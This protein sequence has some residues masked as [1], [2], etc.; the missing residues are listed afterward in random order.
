M[1]TRHPLFPWTRCGKLKRHVGTFL[2]YKAGD[3]SFYNV[4]HCKSHIYTVTG[5]FSSGPFQ[6]IFSCRTHDGEKNLDPLTICPVGTQGPHW[7]PN[8]LHLSSGSWPCI[9]NPYTQESLWNTYWVL[10]AVG[11]IMNKRIVPAMDFRE[12]STWMLLYKSLYEL[13]PT[14]APESESPLL[15]ALRPPKQGF[16]PS[17]YPPLSWVLRKPKE[18]TSRVD[19]H[20]SFLYLD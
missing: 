19:C 16:V 8:T 5:F 1:S 15:F 13:A 11:N 4:T 17:F 20:Q 9:S 18:K 7:M 10:A 6:P 12:G 3:T 2:D 14:D